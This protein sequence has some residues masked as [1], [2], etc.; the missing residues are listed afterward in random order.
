[1]NDLRDLLREVISQGQPRTHRPWRKIIVIVEGL[2][3]MEGT[4]VNLPRLI[5][6]KKQYK[7]YLYV[8]EAHSIGALGDVGGG[9][10]NFYGIDPAHVDILMGTFTKSFGSAGG[11]IAG[12]KTII[13]HLRA[14]NHAYNYA[15]SVSVPVVQQVISSMKIIA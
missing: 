8:D 12:D 11:Y 13:D 5:E 6:L 10:C 3:S 14:N 2:Y 15:E 1:M 9:V 7:F 4:I